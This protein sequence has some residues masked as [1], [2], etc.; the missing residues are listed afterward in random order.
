[1]LITTSVLHFVLSKT[2]AIPG[3]ANQSSRLK[4]IKLI[5]LLHSCLFLFC[6]STRFFSHYLQGVFQWSWVCSCSIHPIIFSWLLDYGSVT[7]APVK[8]LEKIISF[9]KMMFKWYCIWFGLMVSIPLRKL[10]SRAPYENQHPKNAH[11]VKH[12]SH[13]RIEQHFISTQQRKIPR[14]YEHDCMVHT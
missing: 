2:K 4:V 1:M 8:S 12:I 13:T 10:I 5:K 7:S 11:V 14:E 3:Q 9:A 6:Q